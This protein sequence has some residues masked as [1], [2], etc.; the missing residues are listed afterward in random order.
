MTDEKRQFDSLYASAERARDLLE[1]EHAGAPDKDEDLRVACERLDT[2][3]LANH[4]RY[5]A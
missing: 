5:L 4:A 2:W 3:L 1:A